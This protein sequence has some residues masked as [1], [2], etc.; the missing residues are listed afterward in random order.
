M[1]KLK[2][3]LSVFTLIILIFSCS[4]EDAI[5]TNNDALQNENFVPLEQANHI[6]R[7][8][9]FDD[10]LKTNRLTGNSSKHTKTVKSTKEIKN[11]KGKTSFYVVN[12]KEGGFILLSAD[13]RTFPI[14]AHSN[15]N[16]FIVDESL[17]PEG[18]QLW[19]NDTK[20]QITTVQNSTKKQTNQEKVAWKHVEHIIADTQK[21]INAKEPGGGGCRE[22]VFVYSAGPLLD[23]S[24]AW[25]QRDDFN[26]SLPY[27]SCNGTSFQVPV[28]CVPLAMGLIMRYHQHP[29]N[30]NWANM[31]WDNATNTTAD[32]IADIHTAI[33]NTYSNEPSYN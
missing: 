30:Y 16:E 33:S 6:A 12:Y 20:Q 31:P 2:Y 26:N 15:K 21:N 7:K 9:L 24:V 13:K 5:I 23:S 22:E 18:L 4:Q 10:K 28:G 29:T 1:K 17:Y 3:S 11:T 8:I 25:E 32:F 19:I 14:L 27:I